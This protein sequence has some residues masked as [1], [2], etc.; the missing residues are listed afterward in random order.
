MEQKTDIE[1]SD[2]LDDWEVQNE[3]HNVALAKQVVTD[4]KDTLSAD[5]K[6]LA[7]KS[8]NHQILED[9]RFT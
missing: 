2:L 8:D 3:G 9:I 4:N 5:V 6:I 7:K 1:L